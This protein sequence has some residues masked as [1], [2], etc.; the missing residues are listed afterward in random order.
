MDNVICNLCKTVSDFKQSHLEVFSRGEPPSC[1]DCQ[2]ASEK[3]M[4]EG[5]RAIKVGTLRPNIILYNEYH[6]GGDQIA[7]VLGAD[8]RRRP[9]LLIVMGKPYKKKRVVMKKIS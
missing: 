5:K 6:S 4:M 2:Q 9:D 8:L 7:H 3:R 1:L